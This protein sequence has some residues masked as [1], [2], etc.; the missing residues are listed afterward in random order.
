MSQHPLNLLLRFILELVGLWAL[1]YWGWT[2][3]ASLARWLWTL[4]L[5]LLAAILWGIF[6]VDD[7]PGKAPMRVPGFVRLLLEVAYFGGA[8]LALYAA[9][10]PTWA[11]ILGVIILIHYALSWDRIVWLLRR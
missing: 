4:G 10:R 3:H 8:T 2:Q 1:G 6:R 7:D 11:A 9:N 5:P